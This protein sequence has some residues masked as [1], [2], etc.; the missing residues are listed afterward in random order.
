MNLLSLFSVGFILG[1]TGAMAPGPLLTVTI[2]ESTRRGGITGP[3]I[4]LGHGILEMTLVF[5]IVLGAGRFL[6]N[7]I[8]FAIISLVGGLVLIYMGYLTIKGLGSYKIGQTVEHGKS[9]LHPVL[10]G[11]LISLSNPYW[12]IW[13]ITIGMGYVMFARQLGLKGIIA[14]FVG[15]I[16]SD[17]VWYSFVSYG[18]QFG[19]RF[20]NLKIIK[21][22]LFICS[23][24][25]VFF[26]VFFIYKGIKFIMP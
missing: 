17:L 15:H 6:H 20:F 4:V 14:F 21:T 7:N 12:F 10:S 9:G 25:L 13:W 8:L 22:T 26:G 23:I 5:L 16:L 19:G 3:L 2:G 18:I 11:I 24:F 1:L